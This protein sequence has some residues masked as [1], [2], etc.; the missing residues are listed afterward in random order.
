MYVALVK[1]NVKNIG[2]AHVY[3]KCNVS[4]MKALCWALFHTAATVE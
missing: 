1:R 3:S 4:N 2:K